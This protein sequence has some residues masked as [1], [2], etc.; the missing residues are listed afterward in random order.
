[1]L[2]L[3]LLG[4]FAVFEGELTQLIHHKLHIIIQSSIGPNIAKKDMVCHDSKRVVDASDAC[5]PRF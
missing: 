1:M 5:F 3:S 2:H 4:F